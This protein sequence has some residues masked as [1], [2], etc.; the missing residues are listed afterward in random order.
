MKNK[1]RLRIAGLLLLPV[2]G[3]LS[4][5]LPWSASCR[6]IRTRLIARAEIKASAWQG[7][8]PRLASLSGRM[9]RGDR[10]LKGAEIEALYSTSGWAVIANRDGG[11][12]I[13]DITWYPGVRYVL[14]VRANDYQQRGFQ[15][16]APASYPERGIQDIGELRFDEGFRFGQ[17]ITGQNSI[18]YLTYD[19]HND[20][21]YKNLCARLTAG[22]HT[23][24]ER[25]AAAAAYVAGK[26]V[27]EE[28]AAADFE[29][30]RHLDDESPREV[31]ERGSRYCGKLSLA[32]A[33]LAKAGNY[34]TRLVNVIDSM[35]EPSAH[36][37]TEVYYREQW[38]LFDPTSGIAPHSKEGDII[39]YKQICLSN[40][41]IDIESA[42]SH[43]PMIHGTTTDWLAM[44]YRSGFHHYYYFR[45]D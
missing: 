37:V 41:S 16:D 45:N 18:S 7:V 38:H 25:L 30:P 17:D 15:V 14:L 28:A 40:D 33:T 9:M 42:P 39:S 21:F 35:V 5:G 23:D 8:S 12:V 24:D 26:L 3:F 1:R 22:K 32:F 31:L 6:D 36:M 4:P 43:L 44:A 10:P 34:T 20:E 27:G 2:I 11:F 19:R 29:S 13:P